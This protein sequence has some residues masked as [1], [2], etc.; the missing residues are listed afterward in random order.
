MPWK[1]CNR[2]S[3]REEFV[4]LAISEGANISALCVRYGISRKTGYKWLGRF[5]SSGREGLRDASRRPR[6]SPDRTDSRM[7]E[8]VLQVRDRHSAWGGRKIR[9]RL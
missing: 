1:E 6:H 3:L 7:E 8:A 2:M 4:S 5:L 9:R